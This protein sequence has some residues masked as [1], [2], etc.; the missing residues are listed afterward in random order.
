MYFYTNFFFNS[1]VILRR[2]PNNEYYCFY[3]LEMGN[4]TR[5]Y[6]SGI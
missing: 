2:S 3:M 5:Q 6:H 1:V 4:D